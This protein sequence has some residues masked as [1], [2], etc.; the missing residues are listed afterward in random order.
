VHV[1][2]SLTL[3]VT[4]LQQ[5]LNSSSSKNNRPL[6]IHSLE[7]RSVAPLYPNEPLKLCG[8]EVEQGKYEL[9]AQ[10]PEGGIAVKA[11]ARTEYSS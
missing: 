6:R 7:Y 10:R 8:R 5:K 4:M 9:W 11:T 2:L 1:P 3:L